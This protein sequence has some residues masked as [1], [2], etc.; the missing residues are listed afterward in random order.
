MINILLEG[1]DIDAPWLYNELKKYIQPNHSVVV[2]AFSFRENRV[3]N[4]S[5][6][7]ALYDKKLG[8]FY[9]GIVDGFTSYGIL[10]DNIV[11]INYFTDTKETAAQKIKNADIVYFLGG[12]PDRMMD[13]IKEF[14]L[15]DT[16][17]QHKGIVMGYSAGAVIQLAE[18]HLS[19]D[20]DYPEF[21][22]YEGL[23][24][25]QDFYMEV[26]YEGT[27]IQNEAIQR[28]LAERGKTVYATTIHTGAI[29]VDNGNIKLLGDVKVYM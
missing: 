24:Y 22:Y 23:P 14:N 27:S 20:D 4:L 9:N 2:V 21:N 25:L 8:K 26:H 13:R 12:M 10:E 17:M 6:W 15:Y 3:K 5:D 18:Y 28:V 29:L 1:Y 19:P 7:N 11:F 16:L